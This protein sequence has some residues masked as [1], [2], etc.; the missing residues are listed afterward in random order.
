MPKPSIAALTLLVATLTGCA[1]ITERA[2]IATDTEKALCI[3]WGRSL[4]TRS[5]A[6]TDQTRD[7]ITLGYGQ[8]AAAC[9]DHL[10]LLP[11]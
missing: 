9:P 1:S 11:E 5:R 6:D 10:N 4:P 2:V 3:A 7:E 8:F